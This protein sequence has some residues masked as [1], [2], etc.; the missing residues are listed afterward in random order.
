MRF[1]SEVTK[2]SGKSQARVKP[3]VLLT[4]KIATEL[5][6]GVARINNSDLKREKPT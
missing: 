4:L 1:Y 5:E 3:R 6:A 2:K